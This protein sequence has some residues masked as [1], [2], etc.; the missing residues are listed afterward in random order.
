MLKNMTIVRKVVLIGTILTALVSVC[1]A[2][3][4]TTVSGNTKGFK[5]FRDVNMTMLVCLGG[6]YAQGLQTEQ[7]VRNIVINP[8]D[9]NAAANF[10]K[11]LADFDKLF[12]KTMDT[13][14]GTDVAAHL[15]QTRIIW[16]QSVELKKKIA[17][18]AK[19]GQVSE[20][21]DL[22]VKE[23]TPKWRT[24]KGAIL[25]LQETVSND[26]QSLAASIDKLNEN[27]FRV[28]LS[29]LGVTV[30][31]TI[32]MLLLLA[33]DLKKRLSYITVRLADV[34]TGEGDLT[35]RIEMD[36]KDELGLMASYFN[37]SWE[38]LDLMI[39]QVVEHSTLVDTYAGQLAIATHRI[40]RNSREIAMQSSAVATASEEMS[41]TS[42][43]IA[44]NCSVAAG[45][46]QTASQVADSGQ[47]VVQKTIDR[48]GSLKGEVQASSVVIERLGVSSERIGEIAGTIQDI[49]DQTNLLAL[50]AAIEA[51]RAGEM[52]RGFA[53]VADEVR[54]LAVRT[55]RATHE[56]GDV[57]KTIQIESDQAVGAMKR[58]A[59]EVDSG[60]KEAGESGEALGHI[61]EQVN[62]V[63][64]QVSQIATAAEEQTATTME[65]VSNI[66]KIS[67]AVDDFDCTALAVN[68]KVQQ[69][70]SLA[71]DLKKSTSVFKTDVSPYLILDTAKAD[72]VQFVNRIGLCLD[73]KEHIQSESLPDHHNCRFGKWYES[74]GKDLCSMSPSYRLIIEPHEKMHRMAK[75]VVALCNRGDRNEAEKV[76]TQVEDI[77]SEI[78][79]LLDNVKTECRR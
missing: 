35:K 60:V 42:N 49:A 24:F 73:G 16:D 39:A 63:A 28:N 30:G 62:D 66:S 40:T 12:N 55:V 54:A 4:Y 58:S 56:I 18:L 68:N 23:E 14:K 20:A 74:N 8:Q 3:Y 72:H 6:I 78:V 48:M 27:S 7:A 67:C 71:D 21:S 50:N 38:K 41:A 69:L 25:T 53:V 13:A 43:D 11:A 29:I 79:A 51:A 76:L 64:I 34:A 2:K 59:G 75:D 37:Q 5:Q 46:S 47:L 36:S 52:G 57:I 10:G 1:A 9:E 44:R 70:L 45:N 17:D 15:G 19:Q 77:S 61:L 31:I 33:I 22:L 65:I 26:T 32:L